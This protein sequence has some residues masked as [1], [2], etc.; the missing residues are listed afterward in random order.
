MIS[1]VCTWKEPIKKHV[2]CAFHWTIIPCILVEKLCV[3][4]MPY[5]ANQGIVLLVRPQWEFFIFFIFFNV[6]VYFH[7]FYV[8]FWNEGL[9]PRTWARGT[10]NVG[11]TRPCPTRN[12]M[13]EAS[14]STFHL[15]CCSFCCDFMDTSTRNINYSKCSHRMVSVIFDNVHVLF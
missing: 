15:R 8:W 9:A 3:N 14:H 7:Y 12:P 11:P 2:K 5:N 4:I 6:F 1:C 13:P 10:E